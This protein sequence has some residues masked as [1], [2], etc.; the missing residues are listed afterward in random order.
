MNSSKIAY[1]KGESLSETLI[2]ALII[3]LA[4]IMLFSGVRV[5]SSI[6]SNSSKVYDEYYTKLNEN[7]VA[8][9]QYVVDYYN[10]YSEPT[11]FKFTISP[12]K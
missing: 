6:M 12:H 11:P 10:V 2:A 5:G 3:S 1:S 9:A 7:E 8:Q 4:M